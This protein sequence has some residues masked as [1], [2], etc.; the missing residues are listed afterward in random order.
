MKKFAIIYGIVLAVI[1]ALALFIYVL[2]AVCG[3]IL[4]SFPN[5]EPV[6]AAAF[7]AGLV[8][9]FITIGSKDKVG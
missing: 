9:L 2:Q 6:I 4:R 7:I 5:S 1:A 8:A 3:F